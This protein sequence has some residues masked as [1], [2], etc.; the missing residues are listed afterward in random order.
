MKWPYSV[1]I[2]IAAVIGARLVQGRPAQAESSWSVAAASF[3]VAYMPPE[4][5]A[6]A[7]WEQW[8]RRTRMLETA[9]QR[10]NGMFSL[11]ARIEVTAGQCNTA[12]AFWYS[13]ERRIVLCYEYLQ[14]VGALFN[15]GAGVDAR[16]LQSAMEFTL[17]HELGHGLIDVLDLPVTGREEDAADQLAVLLA[18]PDPGRGIWPAQYAALKYQK[19]SRSHAVSQRL[20]ADEHGLD[21]QRYYNVVCWLYGSDPARYGAYVTRGILPEARARRCAREREQINRSWNTLLA[22]HQRRPST[23]ASVAAASRATGAAPTT[24]GQIRSAAVM[25]VD[26]AA[27]LLHLRTE[28]GRTMSVRYDARTTTTRMGEEIGVLALG[29]GTPV[30][31]RLR[32]DGGPHPYAEHVVLITND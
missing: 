32:A 8:L 25:F 15:N 23:R 7:P 26:D 20:Y 9:A 30:N 4:N 6:L 27:Q 17:L 31:L 13:R 1:A 11:P 19:L 3:A 24:A 28:D 16:A 5:P 14:S 12:N 2:A 22:R 21:A 10:W 18:A 29:G